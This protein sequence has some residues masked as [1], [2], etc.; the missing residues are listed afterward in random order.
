[1]FRNSELKYVKKNKKGRKIAK[2]LGFSYNQACIYL[3][4]K[5]YNG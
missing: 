2:N 1:M 5:N 4:K 3:I